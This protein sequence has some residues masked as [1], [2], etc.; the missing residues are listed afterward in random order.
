MLIGWNCVRHDYLHFLQVPWLAVAMNWLA[1]LRS[2]PVPVAS[3]TRAS[4]ETPAPRPQLGVTRLLWRRSRRRPP[5]PLRLPPHRL[6][7]LLLRHKHEVERHN[8]ARHARTDRG[9]AWGG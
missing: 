7:N 5:Q 3:S 1:S 8:F 4:N 2:L 6:G 9:P